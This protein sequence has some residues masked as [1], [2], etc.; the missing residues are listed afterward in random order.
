MEYYSIGELARI[1][2]TSKK[3]IRYYQ[4]A[5]II[6]PVISEKNHYGFYT[7]RDK[8]TIEKIVALK[9]FGLSIKETQALI[10]EKGEDFLADI[11]RKQIGVIQNRIS[12]LRTLSAILEKICVQIENQKDFRWEKF[13][14][15][16]KILSMN[17]QALLQYAGESDLKARI[18]LH[19]CCS[20]NKRNWYQWMF[21]Q[22]EIEEGASI[23]ETG[24]GNGELWVQNADRIQDKNI[25]VTLTDIS[26]GMIADAKNHLKGRLKAEFM[27]SD[28]SDLPVDNESAD[29]VIANHVLF[30]AENIDQGLA[31]IDRVLKKGG[32]LYCS[33][34]G[35]RH[36]KEVEEIV[37]KYDPRICLSTIKLYEIFGLENAEDILNRYFCSVQRRDYK[38]RLSVTEAQLLYDY[39][40]SCHGNQKDILSGKENHFFEYLEKLCRSKGK[41]QIEKQAGMFICQKRGGRQI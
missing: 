12:D 19:K 13:I 35:Q 36:M 28:L 1:T 38:D 7:D 9:Y 15:A 11:L 16:F 40:M 31:E 30:Y 5:G 22:Y 6:H 10:C 33:A 23:L 3:A 14:R 18:E 17:H 8:K 34:Y 4:E 39:I 32:T 37:K 25:S 21:D 27:I 26:A 2:N 20:Q 24:C 29:I 41:I